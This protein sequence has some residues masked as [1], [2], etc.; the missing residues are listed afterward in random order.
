[1]RCSDQ[2][3]IH[4]NYQNGITLLAKMLL[5]VYKGCVFGKKSCLPALIGAEARLTGNKTTLCPPKLKLNY[6][7]DS[8]CRDYHCR[9]VIERNFD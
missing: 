4:S 3:Q 9:A 7:P 8:V 5:R 6:S 1:M 2:R